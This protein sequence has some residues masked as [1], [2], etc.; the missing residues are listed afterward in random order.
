[1]CRLRMDAH[2]RIRVFWVEPRWIALVGVTFLL[3]TATIY[4]ASIVG[5]S[6]RFPACLRLPGRSY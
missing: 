5:G 1:M 3:V 6:D 4:G 2:G